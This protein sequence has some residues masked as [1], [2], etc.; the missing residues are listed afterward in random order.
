MFKLSVIIP[1]FNEARTIKEVLKKVEESPIDKEI[2]IVDDFSSDGTRD[3]LRNL[4]DKYK[5]IYHEK[6]KGKGAA[7]KSGFKEATGDIIIIQDADLEYNPEEYGNLLKPILDGETKVV[8]GS[9]FLNRLHMPRY[10]LFYLGNKFLSFLL[11]ILYGQKIS[12]METCYKVFKREVVKNII[13]KSNRFNFEPEITA[14]II[15]AGYKIK[16]VPV[17]YKSRSFEEG[18]KIHWKDG[19]SAIY[20]LVKYRFIN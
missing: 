5:I 7:I 8:Y 15:K 16:E 13:I 10:K 3:I 9:R 14:K 6:N 1:A 17:S 2:I 19:V 12:D 20:T 11:S 4:G 18:K